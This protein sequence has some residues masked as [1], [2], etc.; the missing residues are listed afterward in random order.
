[1][2]MKRTCGIFATVLAALVGGWS[3][4]TCVAGDIRSIFPVATDAHQV[5]G[6]DDALHYAP[7]EDGFVTSGQE[8]RFCVRLLNKNVNQPSA[9]SWKI[10]YVGGGSELLDSQVRPLS[11]GIMVGGRLRTARYV[12][13]EQTGDGYY[14]DLTFSYT[15]KSGDL[16]LPV[17]LAT[18]RG[19]EVSGTEFTGNYWIDT[20]AFRLVA[21]SADG[22]STN[23]VQM[24]FGAETDIIDVLPAQRDYDLSLS[25]INIK[26]V[27]FD[28]NPAQA[29]YAD[30]DIWRKV[31]ASST[32]VEPYAPALTIEGGATND[33]ATTV[34]LWT[35]NDAVTLANGT[36]KTY[37]LRDGRTT[38]VYAATIT[39]GLSEFS[40]KV[41]GGNGAEGQTA[42]IFLGSTPT[43]IYNESGDL[44][45]NFMVR[46]IA[47]IAPPQPSVSV[48]LGPANAD[49]LDVSCTTNFY[50]SVC[51]LTVELS[52]KYSDTEDVT[53]NLNPV[54]DGI[55]D[56][57]ASRIIAVSESASGAWKDAIVSNV[58]FKATEDTLTK[59]FYV[60][61]L[62]ATPN[63]A[64]YEYGVNF[65]PTI[66]PE[67][68]ATFYSGGAKGCQLRVHGIS[69]IVISPVGGT[70]LSFVGG[71]E[72]EVSVR[73]ADS[74]RNWT[75]VADEGYTVVWDRGSGLDSK[76]TFT[77][78][79]PDANGDLKFPVKYTMAKD[80]DSTLT[81]TNPEGHSTTVAYKVIVSE[82][83][84]VTL[85]VDGAGTVTADESDSAGLSVGIQLSEPYGDA[86]YAFIVP[87]NADATNKTTST[88]FPFDKDGNPTS[89][90][91]VKLVDGT[92]VTPSA[93][94]L[95]N[96]GL[97]NPEF[98]V[99]LCKTETYDE[100]NLVTAYQSSTLYVTVN[101]VVPTVDYINVGGRKVVDGGTTPKTPMGIPKKFEAHVVDVKADLSLTN[102]A[103]CHVVK[104]QITD[105]QDTYPQTF[106]TVGSNTFWYAFENEGTN[107]VEVQVMDKDMRTP[108]D[109]TWVENPDEA[110]GGYWEE[111]DGLTWGQTTTIYVNVSQTPEVLI[112][113]VWGSDTV[114][115]NQKCEFEITLS[116]PPS[117]RVN[118]AVDVVTNGVS[119]DSF[120]LSA[121]DFNVGANKT[122]V[123]KLTLTNID[124]TD[125]TQGL[126]IRAAVTNETIDTA[127]GAKMC[128]LYQAGTYTFNIANVAPV[129]K[130]PLDTT[131]VTQVAIGQEI[132]IDWL[133]DDIAIDLRD[134]MTVSITGDGDP[135]IV[136]STNGYSSVQSG[137]Y[138]T[139]FTS[140]GDKVIILTVEDKD[141]GMTTLV[142]NYYVNPSLNLYLTPQGPSW[143]GAT[144]WVKAY[145]EA[146]GLGAGYTWTAKFGKDAKPAQTLD[147]MQLWNYAISDAQATAFFY[148]QG[149]QV[150]DTRDGYV[151]DNKKLDSFFYCWINKVADEATGK[152]TDELMGYNPAKGNLPVQGQTVLPEASKDS[153]SYP[154]RN[155]AAIFSL[156]YAPADNVGDI[157]QDTIPDIFATKK[158]ENGYLYDLAGDSGSEGAASASGEGGDVAPDLKD[159][160]DYNGDEDYLPSMTSQGYTLI[161]TVTNWVSVGPAF[162]ADLE[163]R[164][165]AGLRGETQGQ[166][167]GV[168]GLNYRSGNN[169]KNY[170]TIGAW[171][172]DPCYTE[173]ETNAF[174]KFYGLTV[175]KADA[176]DEE[177]AAFAAAIRDSARDWSPENRTDPT[178]LDTDKD[179]F[180]DGFEYY[181][182][183]LAHVGWMEGEGDD[184][185]LVQ[186]TGHRFTLNDI[187]VGTL[188]TSEEI[189]QAF[190][191]TV[192]ASAEANLRDTDNDGLTD[193]EELA[194]GTNP[195]EWD[196]DGDGLSDYWEVMYGLDPRKADA[197]NGAGA[198][199]DGDFMAKYFTEA[200]YL[201]VTL[202][203]GV[204]GLPATEIAIPNYGES[205]V[206]VNADGA[207]AFDFA[208]TNGITCIPVFRYGNATS[209]VVSVSRTEPLVA[210]TY[211][212]KE[213][214]KVFG[215]DNGII[216]LDAVAS[217]NASIEAE[218]PVAVFAVSTNAIA[219]STNA[220]MLIHDQVYNHFGYDPRTAWNDVEGYV[221]PRWKSPAAA[222]DGPEAVLSL[223]VGDAGKAQN[224]A[225]YTAR[226]EYLLLKYRYM[227]TPACAKVD[228]DD[229]NDE[230]YTLAGD[231]VRWSDPTKRW[232]VF[233]LG[234]TNPNVP[235]TAPDYASSALNG[236]NFQS[237]VHGADTDGDG[238][239]DGWELYVGHNPNTDDKTD[240]DDSDGDGLTLVQ[241]YAGTDSCNAYSNVP[242]IF[243]N[244]P[245][246]V[247]G[248]YN[249]FFPTDPANADTDGD[250]LTDAQ[251][252]ASWKAD[253][254]Y[255]TT[256]H[257]SH[258]FSFIYGD[259]GGKP[260]ADVD[261]AQ[262]QICIRGG[263]LN[264]CSVDTDGDLLPD[265]WER[266][267][268]GIVFT[269]E[270]QPA[271]APSL[272]ESYIALMRRSDGLATGAVALGYYISGGMDGTYP[273]DS[274]TKPKGIPGVSGGMDERTG[275][276]R[277]YDFDHD[278]LQNFQEY[279]VQALR[280]L[281][282]DDA[283][284]P[285]MGSSMPDGKASSRKFI[286]FL[287]MNIMD[288]DTFYA[289]VKKAG[290]NAT[291]A[292][293]FDKLGYFAP[294]PRAWDK[295]ALNVATKGSVAYDETGFRVMLR[296]QMRVN[297][298]WVSATGYAS[299]DPRSQDTDQDGMDDYYEVFHGL[300]P[301]LGSV[302]GGTVAF[303]VIARIYGGKVCNWMNA[304]TDWAYP[305]PGETEYDA[306]KYPWL[307]GTPEADA[308]G[309]GLRNIDEALQVNMSSPQPTHT[310][311]TPLWYTDSTAKNFASYTAQYY[312]L[313]SDLLAYPWGWTVG[314]AQTLDGA[315]ADWMFA[316][317]E[318]E[319]YD[320]DHDGIPDGEEPRTTSTSLSDPLDFSDPDR[321]QAL[322]FPG[323]KSAAASRWSTFTR[324]NQLEYD[325][326]RQF[327]V[328]A[329]IYPEDV[330]RE[331]VIL[332]RA[333]YYGADSISNNISRIR[334]NFRLGILADGRLYGQYDS[335]VAVASG[336]TSDSPRVVGG[337]LTADTWTH[338]ALTFNGATLALYVNGQFVEGAATTQ[339]PANGIYVN[340]Q[341]AAPGSIPSLVLGHGYTTMPAA[342][343]L[344]ARARTAS[345]IELS[346]T[347]TFEG[348]NPSY[349]S[350]YKGFI[351]EV[352]VWDGA[353]ATSDIASDYKKRYTKDDVLALRDTVY[354]A[355]A[356][357]ATRNDNDGA[358]MLPVELVLH[359]NF[360]TLPGAVN[361]QDVIYEPSG[362]TKNVA[363]AVRA[364]GAGI[365]GDIYCGWWVGTPVHSTVY[366]NYRWVP[367][368]PNTC[369]HLPMMDGSAVDSHY[370]SESLGGVCYASEAGSEK[371]IFPNTMTPYPY[372]SFLS[373]LTW[374]LQKLA[375]LS[376]TAENNETVSELH[377]KYR[378][379][380]RTGFVGSSDLV[381][382]G[383][384]F[385]KQMPEMWDGHGASDAWTVTGFD[386]NAN[387][388]PDWWEEIAKETYGAA[389]G[390]TW[391]SLVVYDGI[392]MTAREAYLRD[393]AKGLQPDG[394]V[395]SEF[396]ATS[397][398]NN[399][400][401]LDWWEN[402]YGY[403]S[404]DAYAD[405]DNDGLSNYAEYLIG[406][407]F[408]NYGFPRVKPDLP[409][410]FYADGQLVPDYFLPVGSLYLGEM[411]ADHDFMEDAWEDKYDVSAV[412]RGLYDPWNDPDDDGWSNYAE[413]R[414]G[415]DPTLI[416]HL[417]VD[418]MT[419]KDFPVPTVKTRL[420]YNGNELTASHAPVIVKAWRSD[421]VGGRPDAVW[422]VEVGGASQS[423]STSST[424]ASSKQNSAKLIGMNPLTSVTMNLGPGSVVVGTVEIMV[425]DLSYSD[426]TASRS[427]DSSSNQVAEAVVSQKIGTA[428]DAV[429][430]TAVMD[431]VHVANPTTGDLVTQDDAV[432]IGSI[433]YMTGVAKIDFSKLNYKY[434]YNSYYDDETGL[435]YYSLADLAQAYVKAVW[436]SELPKQGFPMTVYLTD[437]EEGSDSTAY[438]SRGRLREGWNTFVA[439]IDV[440]GD[441]VWD[442]GEPYGVASDV[443]VGWSQADVAIEMTDTAPQTVRIALA[444]ALA[445]TDFATANALT[446]R[447]VK[448]SY[449]ENFASASVGTQSVISAKT[450][451]RI[452]RSAINNAANK[453]YNGVVYDATLDLSTTP[454][455]T[456]ANLFATGRL[457]LDWGT[458]TSTF[459]G[460]TSY[461][462]NATYRIVLGDGPVVYGVTN[463]N[464]AVLF[465][466]AFERMRTPTVPDPNQAQIVYAGCPTFR[467]Q[468]N[469]LDTARNRVKDY[470]A[471]QA[472]IYKADQTTLVYESPA[473]PAP[474]RDANGYYSWT[475]PVYAGMVTDKGHVFETTNNYYWAVSMLDAKFTS[476]NANETKTPF[477]MNAT[478]N[479]NDGNRHGKIN[480][481]VKYF[482]PLV[483]K[484]STKPSALKNLV[485]VQ[486]FTTPDFTGEP[487][488]AAYVTDV[489][490]IDA[491]DA[492]DINATI[493]G[494]PESTN[495]VY[496]VRAFIDTDGNF[497]KDTWESWGYGCYV[498]DQNAA[499]LT[500]SRGGR[501]VNA[502]QYMY[503]PKGYSVLRNEEVATAT[504]Y[505]E[506]ADT[507]NDGFPD[508]WEMQTNG[509]L[510]TTT[511]ITGN[512]FFAKVNPNLEKT[513]TA[514]TKLSMNNA[515]AAYPMGLMMVNGDAAALMLLSAAPD[516]MPVV[517]DVTTVKIDSFSLTEGIGLSVTSDASVSGGL[518]IYTIDDEAK[519]D[520]ILLASNTADFANTAE[521]T[522]KTITIKAN[523]TTTASVSA[524][525]LEEAMAKAG[526]S[527]SAFLKVKLVQK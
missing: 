346:E 498:G 250:G 323:D 501:N 299:T 357:N 234:T 395:N 85:T 41:R 52:E 283:D 74:Y 26:T 243:A 367:W 148:G 462:T 523:E 419:L 298:K 341:E 457:D 119:V 217:T 483:D 116:A 356:K 68:A 478:G 451:V 492:L 12:G 281:R 443:D 450:R 361:A 33:S 480:V 122:A 467:W 65:K 280:H 200:N 427:Y 140:G 146:A 47:V 112:T 387:G 319:G 159:V 175:P 45:S 188:I 339:I 448:G 237:D 369:G 310:D 199:L 11:M 260:A 407:G 239:P 485:H 183:Y 59:T 108:G 288:G 134:G 123:N 287:P 413:C 247:S 223:A 259:N 509:N 431:R 238:I 506:D 161:S 390:F 24:A 336:T 143:N 430:V 417:S 29:G 18:T 95:L 494:L 514:Y 276:F 179:G 262:N 170:N 433:D 147:Y 180:P 36:E 101:N 171:I 293:N 186:L 522:V 350:Y 106:Y 292:W 463:N 375:R 297:G 190:N 99:V 86:L 114:D 232:S 334:A 152:L 113:P 305:Y 73:I 446:D 225:P 4:Q 379:Q 233:Y 168:S 43:N 496:Y 470:P 337:V 515:L 460:T 382:L 481:I 329:W 87:V 75:G 335:D 166:D 500:V 178:M 472:R 92:L 181:F 176:S 142:R 378:F 314:S 97:C 224:T 491:T 30:K 164:G 57:F 177:V 195:V 255:G 473:L 301:L 198:N 441:G 144:D 137:S 76:L 397:D 206:K 373:D 39:P 439:F 364:D 117:K 304:W 437:P 372:Y 80:Y 465:V 271:D 507:D 131:N 353:R 70:S 503:T 316:F 253:I 482:G 394:S 28:V 88:L 322:W 13:T 306:V 38:Q 138:K 351:D 229:L 524:G 468:H 155:V 15:A 110:N 46:R 156:E 403:V 221:A 227:T 208:A 294:A 118:I 326:L 157:N 370:W 64:S 50:T 222:N 216:S 211:S 173:A 3:Q 51:R 201:V 479:V 42:D 307:N 377:A 466:N 415:T 505:I 55:A 444:D 461:I 270:G 56:V 374:R 40:F 355:W 284:T 452:V 49:N 263:G 96:D 203:P 100:A 71:V 82:P 290:F 388:I 489:A 469:P 202:K 311:P 425:K 449:Y 327:T 44:V 54:L 189:E 360:Q 345:G 277:D 90:R 104:W 79:K 130:K 115:E 458:L 126:E 331:Q 249:K 359:Y 215:E 440:D 240:T 411:F 349:D 401:M 196:T 453:D 381:P 517:K 504:V 111:K 149:Y 435:W 291:G 363:D 125:W 172:S 77:G 236:M 252:G 1:M 289:E 264:P 342:F 9:A 429:W 218:T 69:P 454:E 167:Y 141:G 135:L 400:G 31:R 279:L 228:P 352:R 428:A 495:G 154:D 302:S 158:W 424:T 406:E 185:H 518:T 246:H 300:N 231:L 174:A 325:L 212:P 487:V 136:T 426:V 182:W 160:S 248:W 268:A 22:S 16:A 385:A 8:M 98:Q 285:L 6:A 295:V 525:E 338:V 226:D 502:A 150:G 213:F 412:S 102:A 434:K 272:D 94:I 484:L 187:A 151:Y 404:G 393:L 347:S 109:L 214:I 261:A 60:Y 48:T 376:E 296:P 365:S 321:R 459:A 242:S 389:E 5:Y 519:V 286:G 456:E 265:P 209:E 398:R 438:A 25:A 343:V 405:A 317:E 499:F 37:T 508:A 20:S 7:E 127:T 14:T 368:I 490:T 93:K 53:V 282:Y 244:H 330:A 72:T 32:V 328:E 230:T 408:S 163:I 366:W 129:F 312:R 308:D 81:I 432:V 402:L 245:G 204:N 396:A 488:G 256:S 139:T 19:V 315:R 309:D 442:P 471:F 455:F 210:K 62:G 362:F 392:Q 269:T 383:G 266:E 340:G 83:A 128:D 380:L 107:M 303:D 371:F 23:D 399:N 207:L 145:M 89:A 205:V 354:A 105:G 275:T 422:Q 220:I 436:T 414:A 27:D 447:G 235:F 418:E 476:F 197:L 17:K 521:I 278:G 421:V 318:N 320:T 120:V 63:S 416:A 121:T 526:V 520:V 497:K 91:G 464:M 358:D 124:G 267:F 273:N 274:Y 66:T 10:V 445:A 191:P 475:A 165:V 423:E 34:Y 67:A 184:R 420:V 219:A 192:K 194:L 133:I 409:S 516:S 21:I 410:T 313:P 103:T 35:T 477:R 162:T 241:E 513:L 258:Q 61:A 384:A 391:D 333:C 493:T 58:V 153:D 324:P 84:R 169:G 474:V 348:A 78:L 527:S 2:T 511:P 486:A 344:G 132:K 510:K 257:G 193:L 386:L 512:T 332:E 251:E 254:V